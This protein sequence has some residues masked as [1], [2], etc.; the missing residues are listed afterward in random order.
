[1][2][3]V[4]SGC[5]YIELVSLTFAITA[6]EF[7]LLLKQG[8]DMPAV[9]SLVG[10]PEKNLVLEEDVMNGNSRMNDDDGVHFSVLPIYVTTVTVHLRLLWSTW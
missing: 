2:L 9:D 5:C 7:C 6:A 4:K 10:Y 8:K 3:H 1:M